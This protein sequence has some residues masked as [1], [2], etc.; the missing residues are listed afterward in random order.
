MKNGIRDKIFPF[1]QNKRFCVVEV[2]QWHTKEVFCVGFISDLFL[3]QRHKR[4]VC[5]QSS[6]FFWKGFGTFF[7]SLKFRS[8]K[9]ILYSFALL[10][11]FNRFNKAFELTEFWPLDI[12]TDKLRFLA[13]LWQF[14]PNVNNITTKDWTGKNET[15][16]NGLSFETISGRTNLKGSVGSWDDSQFFGT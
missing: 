16:L 1:Q 11:Y 8:L 9:P 12:R 15:S 6:L 4:H 14:G 2:D 7:Q 3:S 13:V 10:K 5:W